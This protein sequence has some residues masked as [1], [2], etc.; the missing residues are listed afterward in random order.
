MDKAL[1]YNPGTSARRRFTELVHAK[2]LD[3]SQ[4]QKDMKSGL[5]YGCVCRGIGEDAVPPEMVWIKG[6]RHGGTKWIKAHFAAAA[7]TVDQH[8]PECNIHMGRE[9]R[10]KPKQLSL[11]AKLQKSWPVI[12]YINARAGMPY[13]FLHHKDLD[14]RHE[15]LGLTR[16]AP[17]VETLTAQTNNRYAAVSI[18]HAKALIKLMEKVMTIQGDLSGIALSQG[19]GARSLVASYFNACDAE[20]RH[21]LYTRLARS[22][23]ALGAEQDHRLAYHNGQ[24]LPATA[25][26]L[27]FPPLFMRFIPSQ[28]Q[29]GVI[30]DRAEGAHIPRGDDR[31]ILH[32]TGGTDHASSHPI[33]Y[34]VVCPNITVRNEIETALATGTPVYMIANP[35]FTRPTGQ[36][37]M[38]KE[39]EVHMHVAPDM[40]YFGD[41]PATLDHALK[42][43]YHRGD[44]MK[45]LRA[46]DQERPKN[47][48][49]T[50]PSGI[51]AAMG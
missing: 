5:A 7:G 51:S 37:E 36:N 18:T 42:Q 12:A 49:R 23:R 32:G 43:P 40:V 8:A 24:A 38:P 41:L 11:N 28:R 1:R 3:E 44:W 29:N 21:F 14:A 33:A 10:S 39:L 13:R 6:H 46:A 35:V 19:G 34:H 45:H 31:L 48:R 2:K 16:S 30:A 4:V 22:W 50:A 9:D 20:S 27:A 26:K 15:G 47:M 17:S 25:E